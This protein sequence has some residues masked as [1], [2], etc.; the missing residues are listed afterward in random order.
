[1]VV[2]VALAVDEVLQPWV[3]RAMLIVPVTIALSAAMLALMLLYRRE[4]ARRGEVERKLEAQAHT[5]GLT[6]ISNR[7]L[8]DEVLEREWQSALRERAAV[9]AVRGCGP[10][11]RYNDRY[12]HQEGDALL[13]RLAHAIRQKAGAATWRRAMAGKS[14]C[15]CCRAEGRQA[16]AIAE[17]LRKSVAALRLPHQDNGGGIVTL[18]IGVASALPARAGGRQPGRSRG[19]GGLSRQGGRPQPRGHGRPVRRRHAGSQRP[20][21]QAGMRLFSLGVQVLQHVFNE[22]PDR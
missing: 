15:C 20:S 5:D 4:M 2:A 19:R 18:S 3:R 16:L 22:R 6:G 13:R 17:R 1:M 10:F 9:P 12:G 8:F 21:M 11:Q 14:S 7:R